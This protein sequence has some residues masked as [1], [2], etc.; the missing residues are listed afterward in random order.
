MGADGDLVGPARRER[1]ADDEGLVRRDG[2]RRPAL[3][4]DELAPEAA[5]FR[6]AVAPVRL[7]RGGG[8]RGQVV[9]RVDLPVRMRE[10][11]AGLRPAV[12][13]DHHEL[14]PGVCPQRPRP[15]DPEGEQPAELDRGELPEAGVVPGGVDDHLAAPARGGRQLVRR[16]SGRVGH[17][18]GKS[19]L[20]HGRLVRERQ[21][22]PARAERA[23]VDAV[24]VTT[25]PRTKAAGF[26]VAFVLGFVFLVA[27]PVGGVERTD[28]ARR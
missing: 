4:G 2:P 27:V 19:V 10:R 14:V 20:E 6:R 12:L 3:P 11:R 18:R 28:V 9:E 17:E 24:G 5:A 8:D 22:D 13:E 23:A 1:H 15:V 26:A 7:D 21:L 25:S 16:R